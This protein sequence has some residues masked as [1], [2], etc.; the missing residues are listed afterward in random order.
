MDRNEIREYLLSKKGVTEETPFN[1]PVPVYKIAGKMYA[2]LNIHE[3]NRLSINLKY[4]KED[5]EAL[6]SAYHDIVP[7]YHMNKNN[8]NTVYLDGSLKDEFIR[9]LVDISYQLIFQ[10]LTKKKQNEILNSS[11]D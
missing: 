10:N 4:P 2:L 5:I 8:W 3:A 9:E 1:I 6:R 7:G 11:K